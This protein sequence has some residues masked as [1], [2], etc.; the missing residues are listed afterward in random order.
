MKDALYLKKNLTLEGGDY[1][2]FK[3]S[4]KRIIVQKAEIETSMPMKAAKSF[5][6]RSMSPRPSQ[7]SSGKARNSNRTSLPLPSPARFLQ[8]QG[9]VEGIFKGAIGELKK[10]VQSLHT[11]SPSRQSTMVHR[12]PLQD[13]NSVSADTTENA[14]GTVNLEARN[15]TLA[16]MLEDS[17]KELW[18]HQRLVAEDASNVDID[19][20]SLAIAKVQFVQVYL[21]DSAMPIPLPE[22]PLQP[23]TSPD[24]TGAMVQSNNL[25]ITNAANDSPAAQ[26]V[27]NVQENSNLTTSN[28]VSGDGKR[29]SIKPASELQMSSAIASKPSPFHQPRPSLAQSS[30]SWMLG[31]DQRRSSFVAATPFPPETKRGSQ[32]RGKA[33]FLFG[34]DKHQHVDHAGVRK[35]E[36]EDPSGFTLGTLKGTKDVR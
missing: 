12:D 25:S 24:N 14:S 8:E 23:S 21:E 5:N 15:K 6:I 35:G 18:D 26:K 27:P 29:S 2:V 31:E 11:G 32:A 16:K 34:D 17:L 10:N 36:S 1:L 20:L 9:G 3:H 4:R 13:V 33:S 22:D 30:F 28:L 19:A 7:V